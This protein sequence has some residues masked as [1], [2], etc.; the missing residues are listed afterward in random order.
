MLRLSWIEAS[1]GNPRHA[2]LWDFMRSSIEGYVR[3]RA[4]LR[5]SHLATSTGGIRTL[6][7]RLVNDAAV[8]SAAVRE[9]AESDLL[10]IGCWGAPTTAVRAAL[11]IPVASVPEAAARVVAS[12]CSAAVVITVSPALVPMFESDLAGLGAVGRGSGFHPA[13]PVRAFDPE[14]THDDVL[15][16]I[17]E[18]GELIARF[19]EEARRAIEDGADAIVV[20][21]AY[22]A[23]IFTAHG[24][25]HVSGASDVPVLDVNRLAIEHALMLAELSASGIGPTAAAYGAPGVGSRDDFEAA[26]RRLG[27]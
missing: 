3:A 4:D 1:A 15:A 10:V 6:P 21:C 13:R 5:F 26:L 14:S 16:A 23:S 12:F 17:V 19:D 27:R 8:L 7:G 9:E 2:G 11:R 18:P 20:G 25:T 24:Y 22:L